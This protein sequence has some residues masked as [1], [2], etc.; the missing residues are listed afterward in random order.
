MYYIEGEIQPEA[1]PNIL[2]ALWWAVATLTTVG[3]GDVYPITAQGKL[4]VGT[5]SIIGIG[6]IALPT[7]LIGAGFV[8]ELTKHKRT[9]SYSCPHCGQEVLVE[10]LFEKTK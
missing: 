4:L 5:I 2:S 9:E 7:G 3:F 1:F 10:E 8:E 6:I